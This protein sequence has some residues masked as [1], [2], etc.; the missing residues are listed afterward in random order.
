MITLERS[1]EQGLDISITVENESI[2][3][4]FFMAISLWEEVMKHARESVSNFSDFK[5][6]SEEKQQKMLDSALSSFVGSIYNKSGFSIANEESKDDKKA[7][8]EELVKR[9]L[10]NAKKE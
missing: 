5:D 3:S 9:I 8:V 6:A 2:A 7:K 1:G 10:E 4:M